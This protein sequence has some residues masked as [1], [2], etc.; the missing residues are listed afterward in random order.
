M[1]EFKCLCTSNPCMAG[2]FQ[3]THSK[4]P[5]KKNDKCG[6]GPTTPCGPPHRKMQRG[7][8]KEALKRS[9]SLGRDVFFTYS[10][11][12]PLKFAL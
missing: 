3:G 11:I 12:R 5:S 1:I 6:K 9:Q 2:S 7:E 4:Q 8:D 10:C